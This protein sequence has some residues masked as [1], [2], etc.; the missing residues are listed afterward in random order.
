MLKKKNQANMNE[1]FKLDLISKIRNLWNPGSGF[2]Q[3]AFL[4]QF[5]FEGWDYGK[6]LIRKH[7][8]GLTSHT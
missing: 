3:K 2:N 7:K 5:N 8:L 6:Q 1:H 4:N